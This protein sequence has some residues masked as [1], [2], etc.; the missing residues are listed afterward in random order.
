[1]PAH[2]SGTTI[3]Q[4]T[5]S[6]G[7]TS[8]NAPKMKV[9]VLIAISVSGTANRTDLDSTA[10]S[11]EVRVSRSPVPAFSTVD[12]GMDSTQPMNSSRNAASTRSPSRADATWA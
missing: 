12:S 3:R 9:A 4:G 1:M 5:A 11:C 7:A 8:S 6:T 10:T 2:S